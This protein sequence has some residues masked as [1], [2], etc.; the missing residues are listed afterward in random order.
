MRGLI[1]RA[2][3]LFLLALAAC[4]GANMAVPPP[5]LYPDAGSYPADEVA[6]AL[7]TPEATIYYVTDRARAEGSDAPRYTSRRSSAMA[8]GRSVVRFGRDASWTDLAAAS[9]QTGGGTLPLETLS[10]VEDIRFAPTPLPFEVRDGQPIM[11]PQAQATYADQS[12]AFRAAIARAVAERE[13]GEVTIYIHGVR[14]GFEDART[15][16]ATI[17]HYAGRNGVPLLYS[18]PAEN[19][20]LFGYFRDR[21]SGAFTIFHLKE[22]LRMLAETPGVE[23]VNIIAHS[24]GT[25]VATRALRELVIA[26]RAAGRVPRESLGLGTLILAAPDLDF[27]IMQQRLVAEMFGPAFEQINVY[28]NPGDGPLRLAQVLLSGTRFGRITPDDLTDSLRETFSR[29]GNVHFINVEE[30]RPALGHAYFRN[31]PS[32]VSDIVLALRTGEA[33]GTSARPMEQ[34]DVNFWS[35]HGVYPLPPGSEG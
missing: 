16:L 18:W 4:A 19:G 10:V 11:L 27:G 20:G 17:W 3:P 22:T 12:A 9:T 25:E 2:A 8:F 30:V 5:N 13:R 26:E 31:N 33:P 34:R 23:R 21:E 24:Y 6:P 1:R 35:L 14:T 32:V 28:V 15:T 29:I 7:R